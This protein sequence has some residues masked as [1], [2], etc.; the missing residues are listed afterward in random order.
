MYLEKNIHFLS[1]YH[2]MHFYMSTIRSNHKLKL[3][4]LIICQHC[5]PERKK[6]QY[7]DLKRKIYSKLNHL[8]Q[9]TY[10]YFVNVSTIKFVHFR[11]AV[12]IE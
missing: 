12:N 10:M 7:R 11:Y 1:K 5:I 9:N 8:T 6:N 3:Q 4:E 2:Q